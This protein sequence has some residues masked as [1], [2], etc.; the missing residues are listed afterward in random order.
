MADVVFI[1]QPNDV[2]VTCGSDES[3]VFKCQ[4]TLGSEVR[5]VWIINS[6]AYHYGYK[7]FPDHE[8]HDITHNNTIISVKNIELKQNNTVYR[9]QVGVHHLGTPC[10]YKSTIGHLIIR[11]CGGKY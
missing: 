7:D 6:I 3:A 2:V 11:G 1:A 10:T 4:H 8:N 5:P 9:C